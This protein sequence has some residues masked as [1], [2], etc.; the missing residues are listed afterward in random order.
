LIDLVGRGHVSVSAACEIADGVTEDHPLPHGAIK[1]FA[2]LCCDGKHPQNFERDLHR[3]LKNVFGLDLE[4][5]TIMMDL[6]IDG[7]KTQHCPVS[8]LLP[9]EVIHA[10]ANSDSGHIFQSLMLGNLDDTSRYKFWSHVKTLPPWSD[11]PVLKSEKSYDRLI[12][13]TVHADGAV[14]KRDDECF[15]CSFSSCFGDEGVIKD[16][17][18]QKFP[19]AI[20][21]ERHMLSKEVSRLI[22][23][24]YYPMEM[25]VSN[26]FPRECF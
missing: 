20:V 24:S 22:M 26:Y 4:P 17:L 7:Q 16:P 14:M 15:V 21:P 8:V 23:I 2:S 1:A 3:W 9:H 13:V 12:G 25:I 11:H 5:Y 6:Q 10:L 18:L 19:V